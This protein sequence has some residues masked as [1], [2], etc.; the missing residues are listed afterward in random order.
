VRTVF[1]KQ[2]RSYAFPDGGIYVLRTARIYVAVVCHQIGVNGVG[3][4]K[5]N[6]WLSY[7]LSVD[8][9]PI[10]VDPGTYCYTGNM[11]LRRLFRSTAYHN[12]VVVDEQ[13]QIP[14]GNSY[15]ALDHPFG[16]VVVSRWGSNIEYDCL[17]AEHTGYTRLSDPVI[18]RRRFFLEKARDSLEVSDTFVGKGRHLLEW[19]LHLDAGLTCQV[20][21]RL[22]K[23][24]CGTEPQVEIEFEGWPTNCELRQ[25]WV[26]KAYNRRTEAQMVY[27]QCHKDLSLPAT[28]VHRFR[29]VANSYKIGSQPVQ[30]RRD[31]HGGS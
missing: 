16:E 23:I 20:K 5:H 26:S 1:D 3:P 30:D 12:T 15:F 19:S 7:D 8:D 6:D 22:A 31:E 14:M 27:L 25:A 28:F 29:P 10:V 17:E 4:H 11:E 9:Q 18:H 21:G 13:E 24:Y 2:Q